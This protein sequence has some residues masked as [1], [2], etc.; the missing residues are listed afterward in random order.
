MVGRVEWQGE[1]DPSRDFK[2]PHFFLPLPAHGR[3]DRRKEDASPVCSSSSKQVRTDFRVGAMRQASVGL[4]WGG[5]DGGPKTWA[6]VRHFVS[7]NTHAHAQANTPV[8]SKG[9]STMA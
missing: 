3:T 8:D 4:G 1:Q 5:P 2:S 7:T 6:H 9:P